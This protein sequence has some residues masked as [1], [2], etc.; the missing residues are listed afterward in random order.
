MRS[1]KI[2]NGLL[3]K[4][5]FDKN[6]SEVFVQSFKSSIVK[7]SGMA[8]GI[9]VSILLGR[10]LGPDGI[11]IINLSNR[12]VSILL[13][14]A[15]FGMQQVIVKEVSLGASK[16]DNKRIAS[17]VVTTYFFNGILS[18][19]LVTVMILLTPWLAN[20]VFD[21]PEL[22][23]PLLIFLIIAPFQVFARL[24][25]SGLIGFRKIWQASL[26]D[27]AL[28]LILVSIGL[29]VIVF[30]NLEFTVINVAWCYGIS[31]ILVFLVTGIYWHSLFK[32]YKQVSN[33]LKSIL[34]MGF[35]MFV[36]SLT[37][38]LSNNIDILFLGFLS[39]TYEVGL[40]TVAAKIAFMTSFFLAVAHSAISPKVAI[41]Y[42]DE[43]KAPLEKMIQTIT[44]ILVILG[45]LSLLIFV[46]FGHTL[47]GI[48]GTEFREAYLLLVILSIGQFVNIAT[49][50][51]G[52]L[53]SMTGFEKNLLWINV[54]YL[55]FNICISYVLISMYGALG[56]AVA[57]AVSVAL[58]NIFKVIMVKRLVGINLISIGFLKK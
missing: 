37:A 51:V 38:S 49:G 36:A 54:I 35:P 4:L 11:G 3:N 26:V 34:N 6:S 47:L 8:F 17:N 15:L 52:S 33:K 42:D 44:L 19:F 20:T 41:L 43:N 31:R 46:I 24:F 2:L 56:A 14:I 27:Q 30:F 13:L 7:A 22:E 16:R 45:V 18:I 5:S 10:Y 28:S 9:I 57:M 40:Y 29:G 32:E 12:V 1:N 39:T 21:N 58:F 48:W 25:S 50:T 23:I 53:F 55:G